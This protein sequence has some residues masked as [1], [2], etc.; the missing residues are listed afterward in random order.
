M[1][2]EDKPW[3]SGVEAARGLWVGLPATWWKTPSPAHLP[4]LDPVRNDRALAECT[5]E[6]GGRELIVEKYHRMMALTL[7][8]LTFSLRGLQRPKLGPSPQALPPQKLGTR[9]RP[10]IARFVTSVTRSCSL[11]HAHWIFLS[12]A[13]PGLGSGCKDGSG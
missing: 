11:I 5:S 2:L 8:Y 12:P 7:L 13:L 9:R 6:E 1:A 10:C 4:A 3:L